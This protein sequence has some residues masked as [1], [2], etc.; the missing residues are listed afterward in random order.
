MPFDDDKTRLPDDQPQGNLLSVGQDFGQFKVLR[1]L[2]RGGMGEVYEVEHRTLG[3]RHALKLINK[4]IVERASVG[5]RFEREARV[6]A[7]LRHDNIVHVDDFGETDGQSWIRMELV[8]GADQSEGEGEREVPESLADLLTGKPLPEPLVANLLKQIL[9]GL[10]YA[11]EQGVVHRDLKPSNILLSSSEDLSV[12][13]A[14]LPVRDST[15]LAEVRSLG[16]GGSGKKITPK[17]CDFG[18]VRL[19]GEQWLQSQVQLTV[20]C[21][22]VD[23][24]ATRLDTDGSGAGTSTQAMLGTFEFMAPEQKKGQDATA[25]SDLYAVGLMAFRMLTGHDTPGFRRPSEIV[26]RLNPAWDAFVLRAL[27]MDPAVRF[28]NAEEM[29][30]AL[31]CG[32]V[33]GEERVVSGP[34]SAGASRAAPAATTS[35]KKGLWVG[36]VALLL[37]GSAFGY[38]FGVISPERERQAELARIE[39]EKSQARDAAERA[40][41]EAEAERLR[42]EREKAAV[43]AEAERLRLANARGGIVIKTEPAGAFVTVGALAHE[44]KSPF[45][46]KEVKL[47]EYPVTVKAAG[48]EIWTGLVEVKED[49]FADPGVVKLVRKTGSVRVTSLPSGAEVWSGGRKLGTTPLSLSKVAEGAE[50]SYELRLKGYQ[51]E[52][53]S[54]TVRYK[55]EL[56]L[57]AVLE[58]QLGPK[59]GSGWTVDIGGGLTMK[60][61]AAGS[62]EMGSND[63]DSDEKPVHRVTLS[64]GYWLGEHEVTQGQWQAVMGSNPS[65]FKGSNLP[66]EQ[67]SW[68]EAMAFCKKL[69]RDEKAKGRLPAGMSYTLPTEAQWEYACRAGTTDAFHYGN[70]LDSSMANFD[71][72][73]PYGGASKGVYRQKTTSV[74]S[75]KPNAWGLYDMHGNVWE[76]CSDWYG[77]YSSGSVVDPAGARSGTNRVIRGGSWGSS[78]RDC[79]S[80][81]RYRSTPGYRFNSLGFRLALRVNP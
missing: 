41:L 56:S 19:A 23:P 5:Q 40:R 78:A 17:I 22:A 57:R 55:D 75:F 70:R 28:E 64:K 33:N 13:L 9:S 16:E 38:Y 8:G 68:E 65:H 7:Q 52:R 37:L 54:G 53:L 79:R 14:S 26:P 45:T 24:D 6:M 43:A 60:W 62:F 10:A 72:N 66:V 51:N 25:R 4:E 30:E 63:G 3:T 47:G 76:S 58:E 74:G 15:E 77:S 80:A 46:L 34:G 29:A 21:S 73:Y 81:N 67:V 49:Q 31:P 39:I 18:L 20:A 32:G 27:E 42:N 69:T 2:G 71:G 50:V 48:Y 11:H 44:R 12:N 35:S 1:L 36:L 61:I 59:E